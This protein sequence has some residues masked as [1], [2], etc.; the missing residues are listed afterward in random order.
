MAFGREYQHYFY[1]TS[2]HPH[3]TQRLLS[4]LRYLQDKLYDVFE[5]LHV[6]F[7][8]LFDIFEFSHHNNNLLISLLNWIKI[9]LTY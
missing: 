7:Q 4:C 5:S 2:K 8:C 1:S 3:S 9:I 6:V